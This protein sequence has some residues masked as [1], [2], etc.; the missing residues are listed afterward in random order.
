MHSTYV[1]DIVGLGE[2]YHEAF[3]IFGKNIYLV[4]FTF[5][6]SLFTANQS[7]TF[8]SSVLIIKID[9]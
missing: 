6:K 5:N 2:K 7:L 1:P 4:F 3:Y 8:A 9:E